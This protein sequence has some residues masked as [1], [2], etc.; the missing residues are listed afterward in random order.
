VYGNFDMSNE[1]TPTS[2]DTDVI[3][4]L[5]TQWGGRLVTKVDPSTDFVVLGSEPVVPVLSAD[6]QNDPPKVQQRDAMQAA[7]DA[8]QEVEKQAIEL[9]IPILNQNRF[10]YFTGYYDQAAR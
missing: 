5:V 1:G 7:L 10:L 4:R 3:K 8:Y 9:G 6:D 2:T